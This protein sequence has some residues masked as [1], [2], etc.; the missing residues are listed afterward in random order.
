M[1]RKK[2][3]LA[4]KAFI[5]KANT[6]CLQF[7]A[8]VGGKA[9]FSPRQPHHSRVQIETRTQKTHS[10]TMGRGPQ[11][12]ASGWTGPRKI[13]GTSV[14]TQKKR[15]KKKKERKRER[16]KGT[17]AGT[18]SCPQNT[19]SARVQACV[20]TLLYIMYNIYNIQSSPDQVFHYPFPKQTK[21]RGQRGRLESAAAAATVHTE[22]SPLHP[23]PPLQKEWAHRCVCVCG[24]CVYIYI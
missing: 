17:A 8:R 9:D 7:P 4:R 6:N 23:L 22:K 20:Y 14:H 10:T 12:W 2:K 18:N 15:K 5:I 21:T 11:S 24:L 16:E 13:M 3:I 19:D 1:P